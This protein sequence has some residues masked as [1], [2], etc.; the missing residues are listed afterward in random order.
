MGTVRY[1][2]IDREIVAERRNGVR[3]TYVPDLLGST[4]AL[5]DDAQAV[6]DSF[7]YWPYGE[8]R[9][10]TAGS[11]PLRF[12]GVVG[13]YSD[14]P[15]RAYIRARCLHLKLGRWLT[16]DPLLLGSTNRLTYARSSPISLTDGTGLLPD[17]T[18]EVVPCGGKR[19]RDEH[20]NWCG[21]DLGGGSRK[22]GGT[23]PPCDCIDRA[24]K[25]HDL[26]LGTNPSSATRNK[27]HCALCAASRACATSGCGKGIIIPGSK[28]NV[29]DCIS[30][31][32][33]SANLFCN[34]C[35]LDIGFV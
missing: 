28:C 15:T 27:C 7:S 30:F 5:T 26:C 1:T 4:V 29:R 25:Q 6:T 3:R 13:A 14:A 22:G 20:G 17:P 34:L 12:Q 8:V 9:T 24:C 33:Y 18:G 21:K 19:G 23:L 2:T 11:D 10:Q 35:N 32:G 31:A 16:L